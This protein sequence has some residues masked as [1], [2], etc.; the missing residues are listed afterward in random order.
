[1]RM[2]PVGDTRQTVTR[3]LAPDWIS[4]HNT[5]IDTQGATHATNSETW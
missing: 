3:P 1:M 2:T 4:C 5:S